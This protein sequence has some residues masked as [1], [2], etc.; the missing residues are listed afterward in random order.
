MA[1]QVIAF[2][3]KHRKPTTGRVGSNADAIDS[4]ADHGDVIELGDGLGEMGHGFLLECE[5][6]CSVLN[7]L[8]AKESVRKGKMFEFDERENIRKRGAAAR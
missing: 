6:P 4:A 2:A 7:M 5:R 1:G 8:F 3:K